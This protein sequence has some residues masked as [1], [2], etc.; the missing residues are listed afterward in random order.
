MTSDLSNRT[1]KNISNSGVLSNK[2]YKIK[3][4][5][6]KKC[7]PSVTHVVITEQWKI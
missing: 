2:A 5:V 6:D 1:K 4:T 7:D 3:E